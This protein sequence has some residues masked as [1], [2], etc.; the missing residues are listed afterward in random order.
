MID[1]ELNAKHASDPQV[2][3][4]WHEMFVPCYLVIER[5]S[6]SVS[7]LEHRKETLDEN[8]KWT[9]TWDT[10]KISMKTVKG[11][12][13]MVSYN[14]EN[15]KHKTWC[16]VVPNWKHTE[17]FVKDAFDKLQIT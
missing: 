17:H 5:T 16:D 8:D 1:D 6:F 12:Q 7:Y 10:S 2:G 11:F 9:W 4:Y 13:E 15:M 3:D 14:S